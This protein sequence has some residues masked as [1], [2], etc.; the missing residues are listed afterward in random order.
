MKEERG[1]DAAVGA[2]AIAGWCKGGE[3]TKLC[4]VAL[5]E[6]HPSGRQER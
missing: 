3:E 4:N 6:R 5:A 2:E 1:R